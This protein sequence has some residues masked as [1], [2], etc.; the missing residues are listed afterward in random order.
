M[1]RIILSLLI[2]LVTGC[3]TLPGSG[4]SSKPP[5]PYDELA[6]AIA[7]GEDVDA[8]VLRESFIA[9]P[10]TS[11]RL[12]EIV[13]LER[14]ALV[15]LADEPLRLGAIGNAII[16]LNYAS[17]T[18]HLA[19]QRF[20][21]H[22]DSTEAA[23]HHAM[24]LERLQRLIEQTDGEI[25]S[26]HRVFSSAEAE[27][28][29]KSRELELVGSMYHSREDFPFMLLTA[30]K[31]KT[32]AN[33]EGAAQIEQRLRNSYFDLSDAYRAAEAAI[34]TN[35]TNEEFSPGVLIGY[36]AQQ[37]DT[38]A[39]VFIGAYYASEG[40]TDD[41][42]QWLSAASQRGNLIANL[43]LARAYWAKTDTSSGA[44]RENFRQLMLDNYTHAIALG[45]DEAM[46]LLGSIYLTGEFGEE[47]QVTGVAL[48][49]QSAGLENPSSALSLA[50]MHYRGQVVDKNL[51]TA[52]QYFFDA[53]TFGSR[54]ARMQYARFLLD[55]ANEREFKDQAL[56]WLEELAGED[57]PEAMIMLGNLHARGVGVSQNHAQAL[58]WFKSAVSTNETDANIV[59]EVAWTLTVT[60]MPTLRNESYALK[61]MDRMMNADGNTNARNNPAYLDTWAAAYAANGEF[62][63]AIELQKQ[64][65]AFA[66]EQQQIQ[67]LSELEEH[68]QTFSEQGTV[69]NQ[70]P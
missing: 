48:L 1:Q 3:Q 8:A 42:I 49:E 34:E 12:Q 56:I 7:V 36:L 54:R 69:T 40:R 61:I 21:S 24:W 32:S 25:D 20:Y 39:Q 70:V 23:A 28:Y 6:T 4:P 9:L 53:A 17:L 31:P 37:G 15:L 68:L 27:A 19:L 65:L 29:L 35:P 55:P 22:L 64:A 66:K 44:N 63:K 50:H 57:D 41:A 51:D 14:Q 46:F 58:S 16:E 11:E 30:A 47:N 60:H 33:A 43:M 67:D 26:P 45:S 5:P 10:D 18:G 2:V 62:N 59:N 52:E 38:A 13:E